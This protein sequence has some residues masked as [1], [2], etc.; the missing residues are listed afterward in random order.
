MSRSNQ[1]KI[2]LLKLAKT[3]GSISKVCK[4]MGF[5]RVSFYRFKQLYDQGG[6]AAL[7][8]ISRKKPVLKNRVEPVIEEAVVTFSIDQPAYGQLRVSARQWSVPEEKIR[9]WVS[10]YRPHG[11]N[12]LRPKRSTYSAQFKLQVLSQQDREQLSVGLHGLLQ[13]RDHCVSNGKASRLRADCW[14]A[15]D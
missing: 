4:V 15:A 13:W 10:H 14:N 9:T 11:I 1:N 2:G 3:L 12:G 7:I 6:K 8:E 5:S